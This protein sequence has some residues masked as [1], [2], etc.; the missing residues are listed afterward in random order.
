RLP[1]MRVQVDQAGSHDQPLSVDDLRPPAAGQ[2]PPDALDGF[3]LDQ[4]VRHTV[5]S[6][7][8]I[9]Q[10]DVTKQRPARHGRFPPAP[11]IR[12]SPLLARP[13]RSNPPH[14]RPPVGRPHPLPRAGSG[15]GV[16]PAS[17][18]RPSWTWRT[19]GTAPLGS[20]A[21]PRRWRRAAPR[22][23]GSALGW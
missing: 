17:P 9:D 2:L 4:H 10:P 8:R 3:V 16:P 7:P 22:T 13:I 18:R 21:R 20:A 15:W 23:T 11:P 5:V 12:P 6:G 1:K 14:P 19:S